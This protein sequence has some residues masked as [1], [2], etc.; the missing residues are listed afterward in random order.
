MKILITGGAGYIGSHTI[1]ELLSHGYRV[2]VLDNFSNSSTKSLN[3][4]KK[5]S[6][7]TFELVECD[8]RDI[9]KLMNIFDNYSFDGVIHFAGLKAVGES[10]TNPL[11]YYDNNVYGTLNL[12]K[13]MSEHDVKNLVFSSSATVYGSPVSLPL[14]ESCLNL[15]P[16]NPY[17]M[18]K[19]TVENILK[20]LAFSD[21][22]W[23]IVTLRYFNPVGAHKSGFIGENP[24]GVPNNL[25]PFV[26]QTAL[27]K[28]EFVSIYGDD[29]DTPDGT[30]VRDYIHV[31]DLAQGHLRA[32]EKVHTDCGLI[33]V[34]L[35]TGLGHSVLEVIS[36]FEKVSGRK[37][38]YKLV[39]RRPGDVASCI[40]C[41]SLARKLLNW[42]AEYDL[43]AMCEDAWR[44][45]SRYIN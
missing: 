14:K 33:T 5:I 40:A 15:H 2:V 35:G 20:D 39:D 28:L 10:V 29:Y 4:V 41:P 9:S 31:M 30:G 12:L 37:I 32:L 22:D 23:N 38:K 42:E 6:G 24:N 45:E 8:I 17:G 21:S 3:Q 7:K 27:G 36:A 11:R 18:S 43:V 13:A 44:W 1:V 16:T 34:N 25:M 26:S 19:L